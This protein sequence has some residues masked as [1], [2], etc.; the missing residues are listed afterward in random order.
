L[1]FE[2]VLMHHATQSRVPFRVNDVVADV[3]ELG[4][5]AADEPNT[6]VVF[7]LRRISKAALVQPQLQN[8]FGIVYVFHEGR[9]NTLDG[10][11][12]QLLAL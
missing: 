5:Y 9:V 6:V 1:Q 10:G 2:A 12:V 8:L 11:L 7:P 4:F 3:C